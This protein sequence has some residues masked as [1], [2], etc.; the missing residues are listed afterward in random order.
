VIEAN[1]RNDTT[2]TSAISAVDIGPVK[3]NAGHTL[4]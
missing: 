1:F 3:A 4:P 2:T